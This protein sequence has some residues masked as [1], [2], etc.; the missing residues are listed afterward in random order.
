MKKTV[1]LI[2][3]LVAFNAYSQIGL[4]ASYSFTGNANDGSGNSHN[5]TVV[6]AVLTSDR[7]GNTNSAYYF[8]GINSYIDLGQGFGYSTHSFAGWFKKDTTTPVGTNLVISK[9]NN[10][11]Y[12][13]MNSE[14][15][16]NGYTTGSGGGAWDFVGST[17]SVGGNDTNW[18]HVVGTY[19]NVSKRIK[20]YQDTHVDSATVSGY[21]DV[22][23]TPI[24]IGARP[25][26]NGTSST[27]FYFKGG[28]DD[29][30]IYDYSLTQ[31]QVDSLY[32]L[33]NPTTS[34]KNTE[35]K[36]IIIKTEY[37]NL[38]GEIIPQPCEGINIIRRYYSNGRVTTKKEIY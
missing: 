4:L 7:F 1:T 30:Y 16:L 6:N 3:L 27:T 18:H 11:P 37:Y 19:D 35:P 5:G 14:L 38:L 28:L 10:G 25:Y 36:G 17:G 8:N 23:S 31:T 21:T 20:I 32:N 12:D 26:W 2:L 29:F 22:S 33:G 24:Y 9:I 13:V 15:S 34:I